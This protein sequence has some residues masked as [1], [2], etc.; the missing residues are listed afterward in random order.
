[1]RCGVKV[2]VQIEDR[3]VGAFSLLS[4][5]S[6]EIESSAEL[7]RTISGVLDIRTV[8]RSK[9]QGSHGAPWRPISA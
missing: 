8:S 2:P 6:A 9:R 4:R 7:L 1:M 3:V 5:N